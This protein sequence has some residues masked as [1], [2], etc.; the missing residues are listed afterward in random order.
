M[1]VIDTKNIG[2]LE[3]LFCCPRCKGR[4]EFRVSSLSCSGCSKTFGI[5]QADNHSVY[6]LY[7]DDRPN[8]PG[9][10]PSLIW[11]REA[12]ER[13]YECIGYHEIG[14]EFD[15]QLGYPEIVSRFLF[16]RVK[17]R[18][19]EWVEPA[20]GHSV[21]DVGCGAGYFLYLIREKYRAKGFVPA[22]TGVDISTFQLSYM[23]RRMHKE[24]ISDAVA[25]HGNGEYLPF[26]DASFDVVTCSEVI[27][28]I[29]NPERALAEMR[30]VLKPTGR[31]L[32][33]TPSMTAQKGW[34]FLLSPLAAVVKFM[35]GYKSVPPANDAYDLPWYPKDLKQAIL[36]AR[37]KIEEF[38]YNAVIPHPWHFKFLPA[39]FVSLVVS[40]F[41]FVD[42]YLKFMLRP[43]ALHF[44]VRASKM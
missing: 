14:A 4:L 38:E 11:D 3:R 6:D 32:L 41:G 10:D 27:E 16:D 21:L 33:S 2:R 12:F 18:M 1:P 26:A 35:I 20:N 37:L 8:E 43:L 9:R 15:K 5:Y 42:R 13:G 29:R 22:L 23:T 31:L 40:T 28:H 39:P 25:V 24:G 44:V 30:R 17:K 19:L 7:V 34:G 36:S